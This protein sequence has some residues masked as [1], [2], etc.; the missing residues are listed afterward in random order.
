MTRYINIVAPN[1]ASADGLIT[2]VNKWIELRGGG[3]ALKGVKVRIT[4][5]KRLEPAENINDDKYWY[6]V[7]TLK[8]SDTPFIRKGDAT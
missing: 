2:K 7:Y 5:L 3:K 6:A 8:D 1:V 4:T